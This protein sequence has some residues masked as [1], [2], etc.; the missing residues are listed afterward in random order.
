[1]SRSNMRG[2]IAS[3]IVVGVV[4][5]G[6]LLG[7]IYVVRNQ[8]TGGILDGQPEVAVDKAEDVV[9]D[10]SDNQTDNG[11]NQKTTETTDQPAVE[12]EEAPTPDSTDQNED[13]TVDE[14]STDE[15]DMPTTGVAVE[16]LPT[17]GPT[18]TLGMMAVVGLLAITIAYY[19][20]SL[21]AKA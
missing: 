7:S 20:R 11:G 16:E 13:K 5:A 8:L 14:T 2:S 10:N 9:T 6:L 19:R 4:L 18:E 3:F 17:T 12:D 15:E 1:M 21:L